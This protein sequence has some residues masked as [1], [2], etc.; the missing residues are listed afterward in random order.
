MDLSNLAA[1]KNTVIKLVHPSTGELLTFEDG[2]PFT[3][4]VLSKHTG[5]YKKLAARFSQTL[6]DHFGDKKLTEL[7]PSEVE[8]LDELTLQLT[9]DSTVGFELFIDG[10]KA[11][12]TKAKARDILTNDDYFWLKNQVA[13]GANDAANFMPS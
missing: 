9:I 2:A 5:A 12:Y 11:K 1:S 7:D 13:T 8:K 3:W 10:K 4:T 6:R